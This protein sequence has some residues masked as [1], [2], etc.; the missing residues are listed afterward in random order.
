MKKVIFA[1]GLSM[2]LVALGLF[3]SIQF[4]PESQTA[5]AQESDA[6]PATKE[7]VVAVE[8]VINDVVTSGVVN[9]SFAPAAEVP[10]TRQDA[11][12]V[13]LGQDG[14]VLTIRFNV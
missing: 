7:I 10:A 12:G 13:L 11:L 5:L 14:D 9:I 2:A 6:G 8:K 4:S 3:A 1:I